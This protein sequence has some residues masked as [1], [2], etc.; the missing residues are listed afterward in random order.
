M[1]IYITKDVNI[2]TDVEVEVHIDAD[3]LDTDF[4]EE[5]ISYWFTNECEVENLLTSIINNGSENEL[6]TALLNKNILPPSQSK[7]N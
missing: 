6:I 2:D 4:L 5:I 3:D 7:D 1:T